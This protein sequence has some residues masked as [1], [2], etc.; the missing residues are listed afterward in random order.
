MTE[1]TTVERPR[2]TAPADDDA[3]RAAKERAEM[4]QGYYIHLL[5]Y[6]T[7]NLGLF[8]INVVTRGEGGTWWF[9]WP[10]LGWGIGVLIHTLVTF[11]GVFNDEWRERKTQQL[12]EKERKHR[13]PA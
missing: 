1:T 2:E 9:Y 3:Y 4:L 13:T 7:V 6:V 10:M 8:L 11:G 12:Y 5:V